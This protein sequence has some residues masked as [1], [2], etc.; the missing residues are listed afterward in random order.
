[1]ASHTVEILYFD[2]C[3]HAQPAVD[4]VRAVVAETGATADVREVRVETEADAQRLRF[5]GSPSV[6]VDGRDVDPDAADRNDYG[7]QCR[8]YAIGGRFD[9]L[10][11]AT[12]I[13]DALLM[14]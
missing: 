10:P 14:G 5:L 6:R 9:G 4:R 3:P 12:W 7:L 11:A 8:V 2:G 1:M 13:R